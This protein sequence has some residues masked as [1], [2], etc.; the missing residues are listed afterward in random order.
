[1]LYSLSYYVHNYAHKMRSVQEFFIAISAK[2]H[3]A[4]VNLQDA[5]EKERDHEANAS[6]RIISDNNH[7]ELMLQSEGSE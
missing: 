6:R 4:A 5:I 7:R 3:A 2:I 1:M